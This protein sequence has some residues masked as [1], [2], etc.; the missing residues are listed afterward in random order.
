MVV[1]HLA[2]SAFVGGPESQIL[3]LVAALPGGSRSAVLSFSEGGRCRALLDEARRAGAEAVELEQQRAATTAR[4][5]ARSPGTSGGS[6]RA[7]SAATGTS[8][9]SSDSS[10]RS[11]RGCR[12]SRSRTGGRPRRSRSGST[13]PSTASACAAWTG[14]SAS[15]RRQARKVRRAGSRRERVAVIHNAIDPAR[16]DATTTRTGRERLRALFPDPPRLIVGAAGRLSPEKGYGVLVEAAAVVLAREPRRRVRPLRRRPA[17][18]ELDAPGRAAGARRP[19][20]L[21]GVPHRPAPG[22][23]ASRPVRP[24]VVHRGPAGRRPGSVRL[25]RRRGGD[26]RRGDARGRH[27]RRQ[28]PARPA[29]RP[30]RARQAIAETLADDDARL[31]MGERGRDRVLD[32][33][34]FASQAVAYQRLFDGLASTESG[35][36]RV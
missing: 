7:C 5:R 33:F 31:A 9:T 22:L 36:C 10:P 26:G 11:W 16:Y 20:R 4:R 15:R 8:P 14:S 1:V 13:R 6:A 19:V 12:S 30:R 29:G 18:G 17:R 27:R 2:A 24:A 35:V 32:R 3:G 28:R 25:G 21:R 23:S 34:T